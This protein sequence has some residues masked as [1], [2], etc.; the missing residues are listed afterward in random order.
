V[1]EKDGTTASTAPTP[2]KPKRGV[3]RWQQGSGHCYSIDGKRAIGVTTALKALPKNLVGWSARTVADYVISHPE[4]LQTLI[5]E[6]GD[7]PTREFLASLPFQ[8]RNAAAVRGTAVHA[9]ADRVMRGEEVEVPEDLE[10]YVESY[11]AFCDEWNPE[12]VHSELVVASRKHGYAGT[13]DSVQHINLRGLGTVQV[14]YKT[15]RGVYGEVALQ[16]AAYRYADVYLDADGNEQPMIPLD[17]CYVLHIRPEGY[18]FMPLDAGEETFATFLAVLDVYRRA[19]KEVQR[20]SPLDRLIG[21]PLAAP[22]QE[23]AA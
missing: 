15:G 1:H 5:R 2:T 14:D 9:L 12:P 13:L 3:K 6:G 4:L 18:E 21:A 16:T 8:Q 20:V 23:V 22:G 7:E 17:G 10:P 11:I 19:V